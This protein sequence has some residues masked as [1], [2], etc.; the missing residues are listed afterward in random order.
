MRWCSASAEDIAGPRRGANQDRGISITV[1][2]GAPAIGEDPP[3]SAAG[4]CVRSNRV[5]YD[6][7]QGR[8][9]ENGQ[10]GRNGSATWIG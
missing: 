5:D 9:F 10:N 1:P 6:A 2:A 7:P 4:E 8:S 3:I